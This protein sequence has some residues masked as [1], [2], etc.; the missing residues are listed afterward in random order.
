MQEA[1]FCFSAISQVLLLYSTV[2]LNVLYLSPVGCKV[3]CAKIQPYFFPDHRI[4]LIKKNQATCGQMPWK[5]QALEED[6]KKGNSSQELPQWRGIKQEDYKLQL[7]LINSKKA[8]EIGNYLATDVLNSQL[9]EWTT[10]VQSF[11]L[12]PV[13]AHIFFWGYK[14]LSLASFLYCSHTPLV[15]K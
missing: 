15:W 7:V 12:L 2:S 8:R 13:Y 1:G 10:K 6:K 5:N 3:I 9:Q 14:V 4:K 11:S